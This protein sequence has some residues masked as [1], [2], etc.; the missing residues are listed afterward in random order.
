MM[1]VKTTVT[2]SDMPHGSGTSDST[3]DFA[4][5]VDAM[6]SELAGLQRDV[7]L[8]D[9]AVSMLNAPKRLIIETRYLTEDGMDKG[10][11]VTLRSHA[12]KFQWRAMSHT[13]YEKLRDE[14]VE[15]IAGILGE[16]K[17][18]NNNGI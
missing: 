3:G 6:K 10:A 4:V 18:D 7:E 15:Q 11:R 17:G 8:V 13:T 16:K 5:R 9:Y 2:L 1:G 12:R 14:A